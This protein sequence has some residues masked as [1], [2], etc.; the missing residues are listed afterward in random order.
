MQQQR[1]QQ[2]QQLQQLMLNVGSSLSTTLNYGNASTLVYNQGGTINPSNEWTGNSNVAG[3]GIPKSCKHLSNNL[4][5]DATYRPRHG[6]KSFRLQME[7]F[8]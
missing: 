5:S 8:K 7:L 3:N 6:R 4:V 1:L 2:F